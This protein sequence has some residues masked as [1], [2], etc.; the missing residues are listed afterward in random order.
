MNIVVRATRIICKDNPEWGVFGVMAEHLDY[1][2][3]F[4]ERGWKIVFKS[5]LEKYWEIVK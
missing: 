4:G 1:Y 5:E 2:D 3:I